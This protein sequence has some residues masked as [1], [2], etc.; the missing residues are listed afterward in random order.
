[1]QEEL[2]LGIVPLEI[3]ESPIPDP[4]RGIRIKPSFYHPVPIKNPK[5]KK[6]LLE[7]VIMEDDRIEQPRV[8]MVISLKQLMG[9]M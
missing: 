9:G 3:T 6:W 8:P 4:P 5:L 1:M 7:N 2:E